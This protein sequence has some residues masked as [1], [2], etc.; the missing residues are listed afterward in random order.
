MAR[1]K[2]PRK[3]NRVCLQCGVEFFWNRSGIGK[4]CSRKCRDDG[5]R[6]TRL[7][8]C[9][10]CQSSFDATIHPLQKFCSVRCARAN[11]GIRLRKSYPIKVCVLCQGEFK[12]KRGD[13]DGKYCSRACSDS[14]RKIPPAQEWLNK[15]CLNCGNEFLCPP[16]QATDNCSVK[17]GAKQRA[18][19]QVGC[20]HPL[21]KSK[22]TLPC[23]VCGKLV[24]VK[25]S[26]VSRFRACSRSCNGTW[27]QMINPRTSYLETKMA[28]AFLSIGLSA[29][30]Q[31][32]IGRYIADL[33][34][35][36]KKIDV[37]CDGTYWHNLPWKKE[38]D[39]RR[40]A[41][42]KTMGWTV[43]RFWEDEINA[44]PEACAIKVK[45]L[46]KLIG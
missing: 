33:A 25:P 7:R 23:R 28:D 3:T 13:T 21:W 20:N 32:L 24:D 26:L 31:Y 9:P 36:E 11:G 15:T 18:K 46:L 35:P 42:L 45:E 12:H 30:P 29:R 6:V 44:S 39:V 22:V 43:I 41:H 40:D 10:F 8:L 1:P 27:S 37:E 19:L 4:Y 16:W 5:R 2:L 14:V 38:Q 17:C 34:F